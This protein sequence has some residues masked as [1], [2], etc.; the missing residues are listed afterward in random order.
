[1]RGGGV[2]LYN[3]FLKNSAVLKKHIKLIKT[4]ISYQNLSGYT[5]KNN[6]GEILNILGGNWTGKTTGVVFY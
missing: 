1:M 2:F 6:F 5:I 4:D 3:L